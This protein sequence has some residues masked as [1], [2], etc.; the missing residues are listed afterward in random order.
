MNG[1]RM[2]RRRIV[3]PESNDPRVV[4]AGIEAVKQQIAEIILLGNPDQVRSAATNDPALERLTIIDPVTS[5]NHSRYAEILIK[6]RAKAQISI[7]KAK[8]QIQLP[9]V[10]ANCMVASGDADG[11][12]AG[13]NIATA[14]VIRHAI[15][16]VGANPE[17]K[18]ASSFFLMLFGST[19]PGIQG[20][21]LFAD[22]GLVINPDASEL[23]K[24]AAATAQNARILLDMTPV[25]AML[26]FSS[27]GSARHPAVSRVYQATKLLNQQYPDLHVIGEIQFDAAIFPEIFESKT[28]KT[29]KFV[30]PNV[31]IFPNLDAGNIAYK[32][33]ERVAGATAIGPI[34]QGINKPI[35]D[36]SRGCTID[37]IVR[38]IA[39]TACQANFD[40]NSR[41]KS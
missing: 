29:G 8:E 3:L 1:A 11:C 41:G 12:V 16:I 7:D 14:E 27:M 2:S 20:P 31:F 10:Y 25:V 34:L 39:V 37:D 21:A 40:H 28:G 35:N 5:P 30:Q 17:F 36:L 38:S 19:T 32:I 6:A 13:A 15:R 33:A 24:I 18:L 22:C 26:S 23:A 4:Q 9:L